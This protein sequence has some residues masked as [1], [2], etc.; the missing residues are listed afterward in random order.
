MF[1]GCKCGNLGEDYE[2]NSEL[3]TIYMF[4]F[5]DFTDYKYIL[6]GSRKSYSYKNSG[7][8]NDVLNPRFRK[9]M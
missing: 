5:R 8:Q 3:I 9:E 6:C 2:I 7:K 1:G 4:A